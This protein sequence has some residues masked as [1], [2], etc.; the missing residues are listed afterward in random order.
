MALKALVGESRTSAEFIRQVHCGHVGGI[1][2]LE[3]A[4]GLTPGHLSMLL[5]RSAQNVP[6]VKTAKRLREHV[7]LPLVAILQLHTPVCEAIRD[8]A[9]LYA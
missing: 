9:E 7:N 8:D 2:D 4:A 5:S 3:K 1:G 6:S